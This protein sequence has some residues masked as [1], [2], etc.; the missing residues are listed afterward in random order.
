MVKF[1]IVEYVIRL[2]REEDFL[3][4]IEI[5]R[6][7]FPTQPTLSYKMLS[8]ELHSSLSH[9]LVASQNDK[10]ILQPHKI[11]GFVSFW[12]ISGE[13]HITSIAVRQTCQR[14]GIGEMLLISMIE[15]AA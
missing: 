3:E 2:M 9:Y 10:G 1:K 4:I 8:R 13:A 6:E 15:R 12:L 11:L 7:A 14:Q 5:D